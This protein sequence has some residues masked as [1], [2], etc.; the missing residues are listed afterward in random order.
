MTVELKKGDKAPDFTL[1][2]KDEKSVSLKDFKGK[3][4]IVYFY[5]KDDT[6]GCTIEA[7]E[8]TQSVE[9]FA[10]LDAK[11]LGISA[12]TPKSHVKFTDK[13]GL[14]ITL[15]SDEDH[16][17]MEEYGAWGVKKMYGKEY[18]GII[19]STFL[20]DPEGNIAEAWYKVKVKGHVDKVK[21]ALET[22]RG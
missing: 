20:V 16:K 6:P 7:R 13:Y 2:D 15:L 1:P 5:P 10:K 8:F 4:V 18:W 9:E 3:W 22:H 12:D 11:I 21:E 17:V 19:R 14:K